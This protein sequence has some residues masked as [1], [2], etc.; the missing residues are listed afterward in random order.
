MIDGKKAYFGNIVADYEKERIVE[1]IW[2]TE[3]SF[4]GTYISKLPAESKLLDLPVGTGRFVSFY[5]NHNV[6]FTGCDIS[7]DMLSFVKQKYNLPEGVLVNCSAE[8]LPFEESTFEYAI[9]CRL[10]HLISPES[11]ELMIQEFSRVV[12]KE[13]VIHFFSLINTPITESPKVRRK[14]GKT[15]ILS[16]ARKIQKLLLKKQDETNETPWAKIQNYSHQESDV[17]KCF[18]VNGWK[19]KSHEV[20]PDEQYKVDVYVLSKN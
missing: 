4:F 14:F 8:K 3:Q 9:C 16:G 12:T 19:I 17:N 6:R 20:F 10:T 5:L 13:L 2:D 11:L 7:E 18:I 15:L 1:P